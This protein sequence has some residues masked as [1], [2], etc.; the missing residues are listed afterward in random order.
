MNDRS[1][2]NRERTLEEMKSL[3]F[4]HFVSLDNCFCFIIW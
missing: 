3:F 1:F 4:Q 2:E